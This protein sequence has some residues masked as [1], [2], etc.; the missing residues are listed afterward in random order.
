MFAAAKPGFD[1]RAAIIVF[2]NFGGDTR[3]GKPGVYFLD[4]QRGPTLAGL[5]SGATEAEAEGLEATGQYSH[6]A[7]VFNHT[8]AL[9]AAEDAHP[10]FGSLEVSVSDSEEIIRVPIADF[11]KL[12]VVVVALDTQNFN[13]GIIGERLQATIRKLVEQ[14]VKRFAVNLSFGLVPCSV[15]TDFR[16]ASGDKDENQLDL[17]FEE[18]RDAIFEENRDKSGLDPAEF[19]EQLTSILTTP[20]NE[21]TDPLLK[22]TTDSGDADITYLAAS[23][24]Y[25]LPY[26]LYPGYWSEFVS[27]SAHNLASASAVPDEYSNT[28]EIILPGGYFRLTAYDPRIDGWRVY[29]QISIAG[30][31][32]AAPVLSVFTALD[33]TLPAPRC[34]RVPPSVTSPMAFFK[35][36]P[37]PTALPAS[38]LNITLENTLSTY[39]R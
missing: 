19:R 38:G 29:P 15:R 22:G 14:D 18:Y 2:D 30:T 36:D 26:S 1:E 25:A 7:L 8:L 6:G 5:M 3:L 9:L 33:F 10:K 13:T 16:A 37:T 32:F 28:G 12:N 17:T 4:Q 34:A 24:N 39:C 21:E 35:T 31:S 23:G 11:T 20:I 27:V